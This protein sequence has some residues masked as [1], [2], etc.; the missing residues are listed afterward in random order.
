MLSNVMNLTKRFFCRY[1][2]LSFLSL[3]NKGVAFNFKGFLQEERE[4][5]AD[6]TFNSKDYL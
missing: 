6:K 4:I 2:Q 5:K 3:L 1:P